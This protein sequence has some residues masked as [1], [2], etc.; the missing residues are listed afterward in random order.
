[1][2]PRRDE[3]AIE[4]SVGATSEAVYSESSKGDPR[5]TRATVSSASS[6]TWPTPST[7]GWKMNDKDGDTD[8]I[9]LTR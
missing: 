4:C 5:R 9:W 6:K 7:D 3:V 8:T 2:V 1:M